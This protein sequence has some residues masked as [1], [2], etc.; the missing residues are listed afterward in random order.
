MDMSGF[1]LNADL[2]III[3][4]ILMIIL[5]RLKSIISMCV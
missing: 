5:M 4:L 1:V 2:Q 3:Y